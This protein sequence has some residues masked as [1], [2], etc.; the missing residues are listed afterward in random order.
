MLFLPV[1]E[2]TV[3]VYLLLSTSSLRD[4][5]ERLSI[6]SLPLKKKQTHTH[7]HTTTNTTR[8]FTGTTGSGKTKL[9]CILKMGVFSPGTAAAP[10]SLAINV[11]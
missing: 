8:S 5:A 3:S 7:T 1:L 9:I 2:N 11:H 10:K 6:H 4:K